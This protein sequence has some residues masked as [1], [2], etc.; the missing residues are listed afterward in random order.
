MTNILIG[1]L[2]ALA[3]CNLT[4]GVLLMKRLK[5]AEAELAVQHDWIIEATKHILAF[6]ED[7]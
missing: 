2:A 7:K 1:V 6:G 3:S 5:N 4:L